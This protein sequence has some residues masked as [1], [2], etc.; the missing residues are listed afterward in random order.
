MDDYQNGLPRQ[1]R[2]PGPQQRAQR[3]QQ[4]KEFEASRPGPPTPHI[5]RLTAMIHELEVPEDVK[6]VAGA[7]A[8]N[9]SVCVFKGELRVAIRLWARDVPHYA[10]GR[11]DEQWRLVGA[12]T[13]HGG[14]FED[15]RLFDLGGKLGATATVVEPQSTR[16]AVLEL[17]D[18]GD[19]VSSRAQP[20]SHAEKNWMPAVTGED[21]L[22]IVYRTQPPVIMDY[23]DG[24]V[25]PSP[26]DTADYQLHGA[27]RGGSQLLPF[28]DGWIAVVHERLEG[29]LYAHR[30][31]R[32][33]QDLSR[34]S[35][36]PQFVFEHVGIEFACGLAQWRGR[37][38]VSF[39]SEDR[40]ARIAV[41][42]SD[43][44]AAWLPGKPSTALAKGRR[45]LVCHSS[46]ERCGV[47]EYGRQLDASL[48]KAGTNLLPFTYGN[49]QAIP[50]VCSA[51][52]TL[53]VHYEPQLLPPD[54]LHTLGEIKK[55]GTRIVLCCH[56]YSEGALRDLRPLVDEVV[57][58]RSY[59]DAGRATV[60]PL[61]CP[62]YEPGDR[63][64]LRRRLGLSGVVV[65]TIGLLAGW[66]RIPET[67]AAI[68]RQAPAGVTIVVQT[69]PP[70]PN[71][72][73]ED[74]LRSAIAPFGDKARL[75]TR[76]L[77][78]TDLLDLV[79]ASDVGFVFHGV[80]TQSVS[81]ATKQFVS[82]RT[83][84]VTTSSTHSSD[85][86]GVHRVDSFD[87]DV[88]AREVLR[89][90]ADAPLCERMRGEMAA[91]YTRLN[92]DAVAAHYMGVL[93]CK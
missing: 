86:N 30:F 17:N 50:Q 54:F 88:F 52:D 18:H 71:S 27:M 39:G 11:I 33:S 38:I 62:V 37:W 61:G 87:P 46:L 5:A 65:T 81:A 55:R 19:V 58:H 63:E 83:P 75:S 35:A 68:A 79:H 82:A 74:R 59:P 23:A 6:L 56:W 67:V 25:W 26:P 40:R 60:I 47:R 91:E 45:V 93:W 70:S 1:R 80:H 77:P 16:V 12:R 21:H 72:G 34:V 3:V 29:S 2:G 66:K 49:V 15:L 43:E 92:M 36:G 85:L 48:V 84:L 42:T 32:F 13:M 51:G 41:L 73:E 76:F 24:K 57:V 90:A 53:L 64:A 9:P 78:E 22:R 7:H 20:S 8:F 89:V 10:I 69:P 28:E 14:Q 44:L 4:R 31:V